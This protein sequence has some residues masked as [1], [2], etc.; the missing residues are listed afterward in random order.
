MMRGSRRCGFRF[1]CVASKMDLL[2]NPAIAERN[3]DDHMH[4]EY[5]K[6]NDGEWL[7]HDMPIM[8]EPLRRSEEC[9]APEQD[10]FFLRDRKDATHMF[11]GNVQ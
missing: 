6:H 5:D 2:K 10:G 4:R 9:D 11:M 8:K 1:V 7:M 3:C